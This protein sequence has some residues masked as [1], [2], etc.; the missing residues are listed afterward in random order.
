[1]AANG[2]ARGKIGLALG[3]GAARGW[4]HIGVIKAL[5][6]AGIVP[7]IIAGTSI[8][9]VVG[10]CYA[11]GHLDHLERFARE[12]TVRRVFGYL[13][14]NFAG[15]GLIS[16]QKLCQRLQHDLGD[17]TIDSLPRKF[18]AVATEIG[19]GH[20]VWLSRGG[21]VTA[22]RA[23]Y[24]LPGIFR[25]VKIDGRWLFDGAL[26]NPIPVTVCRALGA[27]YVIAVN[28]NNDSYARGTVMPHLEAFPHPEEEVMEEE[29]PRGRGS[30]AMRRL[31][32]RQFF[33]RGDDSPGI[34]TV[35]VDAFN[36]VQDRISRSRLAGDPPDAMISPR[37]D[38]IGLF[39]FHRADEL[40]RS[41]E[42]AAKR[43]IDDLLH[44]IESRRTHRQLA[45]QP[46]M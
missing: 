14:F 23:S 2:T 5:H 27:R 42:A 31:L 8:G 30:A 19:S 39:D 13:D 3:G 38:G 34:S 26:V 41:G 25:P 10:G 11:A 24:A 29:A 1:M 15:T 9:A 21:L 36:I 43:E 37:T 18:T 6:A 45:P 33:G 17:R 35:M 46:S 7:D 44:E 40:I 12:L 16:G 28:L 20:E 22:M 4:A 32:Q